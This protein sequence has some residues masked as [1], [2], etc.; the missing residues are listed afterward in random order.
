MD[1]KLQIIRKKQ[2]LRLVDVA[3]KSG[4]GISTIWLVENGYEGIS[5]ETKAKLAKGLNTN[6]SEL[7]G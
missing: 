1:N 7:F 3:K 4:L 5:E 2:G 6:V